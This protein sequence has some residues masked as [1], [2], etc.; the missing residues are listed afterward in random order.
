[1]LLE[2]L[3]IRVEVVAKLEDLRKEFK[4]IVDPID[5]TDK[6]SD[7]FDAIESYLAIKDPNRPVK[8]KE[9]PASMRL[10]PVDHIN[11]IKQKG[12]TFEVLEEKYSFFI[13]FTNEEIAYLKS[14][15]LKFKFI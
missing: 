12:Y 15:L 2:T 11:R 6:V 9:D 1:M 3:T 14:E 7:F 4:D 8:P 5:R 10:A 13:S